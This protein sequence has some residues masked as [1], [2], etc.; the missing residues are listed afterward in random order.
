MVTIRPYRA[1]DREKVREI[2]FETGFMGESVAW[3]WGDMRSFSDIWTAYYT[4]LEPEST[5]VAEDADSVMGYLLGCVDTKRAPSPLSAITH[6][7]IRR[8]LLFRFGTAGFIWRS[9]W[10]L[11]RNPSVLSGEVSDP[12]W[13]SHLH[14]NLLPAARGNGTGRRLMQ[15][16]L[17]RMRSVGSPGCHLGVFAENTNAIAFFRHMGFE[18]YGHP[19]LVPGMRLTSGARMHLQLMVLTLDSP[20]A[21]QG[22]GADRP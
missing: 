1:T 22:N 5:F 2:A 19:L 13:P 16:W 21:K 18:L 9:I 15:A 12:R 4:D 11:L 17:A 6:Q 10:D 14:I 3:Y 7:L 20:A 8:Q